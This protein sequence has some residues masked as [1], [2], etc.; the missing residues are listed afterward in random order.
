MTLQTTL[1]IHVGRTAGAVMT[2]RREFSPTQARRRRNLRRLLDELKRDGIPSR[3]RL[4]LLGLTEDH[5][6]A[7][8]SGEPIDDNLARYMEWA[9]HRPRGWVDR[10]DED[11]LV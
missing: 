2:A 4:C 1:L 9:M 11:E 6:D 5:F 8:C 7:I 3:T 10:E